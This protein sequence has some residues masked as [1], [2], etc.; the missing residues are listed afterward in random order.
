MQPSKLPHKWSVLILCA[1]VSCVYLIR[2]TSPGSTNRSL[3]AVAAQSTMCVGVDTS[4]SFTQTQID[5]SNNID[6]YLS[7]VRG[8]NQLLDDINSADTEEDFVHEYGKSLLPFIAIGLVLSFFSIVCICCHCCDYKCMRGC[9]SP[10]KLNKFLCMGLAVLF[11]LAMVA[12][13]GAGL[14]FTG[15]MDTGYQK[16]TCSLSNFIVEFSAGNSDLNWIGL[17]PAV[18]TIQNVTNS[19]NDTING[20]PDPDETHTS[21]T[22]YYNTLNSSIQ[23]YY[24]NSQGQT[25]ANPADTSSTITPGFIAVRIYFSCI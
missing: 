15:G 24:T 3:Q 25:V 21:M 5:M 20:L 2:T 23:S 10:T 6:K 7:S 16:G 17:A 19:I 9:S 11:S 1:L 22:N 12:L 13:A 8:G 14:Y 4:E 18:N